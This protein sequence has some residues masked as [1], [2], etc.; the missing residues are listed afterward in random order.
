MFEKMNMPEIFAYTAQMLH[1]TR[2]VSLAGLLFP[3]TILVTLYVSRQKFYEAADRASQNAII[4]PPSP[5]S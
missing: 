3:A 4:S 2:Y 5:T 1:Y